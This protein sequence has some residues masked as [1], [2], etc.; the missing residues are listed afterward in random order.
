MTEFGLI[1][2]NLRGSRGRY[3]LVLLLSGLLFSVIAVSWCMICAAERSIAALR[4]TYGGTAVVECYRCSVDGEPLGKYG[5]MKPEDWARLAELPHAVRV[6]LTG[7]FFYTDQAESVTTLNGGN[8]IRGW[9]FCLVGYNPEADTPFRDLNPAAVL[10]GRTYAADTECVV[11]DLTAAQYGLKLGDTVE[12]THIQ[13]EAQG[14]YTLVGI[15][16]H[17]VLEPRFC[18]PGLFQNVFYTTMTGA[19]PF[20]EAIGETRSQF[21]SQAAPESPPIQTGY[22]GFVELD[23]YENFSAFAGEVANLQREE[24]GNY[25]RFYAR[26]AGDYAFD[27]IA[28]PL[29]AAAQRFSRLGM[30]ALLLF[31]GVSF[32]TAVV[33]L[34]ARRQ[35]F[36]TLRA[37]GMPRRQI[38]LA[39]GAEQAVVY[40]GGVLLGCALAAL[41][42]ALRPEALPA[43]DAA[44]LGSMAEAAAGSLVL[45]ALLM[46][47]AL[48]GVLRFRPM[49]LL[50]S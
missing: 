34:R 29:M 14:R 1:L 35:Q 8:F 10:E 43:L 47:V 23:S 16:D 5:F 39:Y 7:C 49:K 15:V 2:R 31:V 41:A 37:M 18:D 50:R 19:E 3:G 4:Q 28:N 44:A 42:M 30:L 38:A 13:T 6:E 32:T 26:Y 21:F 33:G 25:Y 46:A 27:E 45:L 24:H 11:S 48:I 17:N 40:L 36:G 12:F 20:A 9:D 22:N